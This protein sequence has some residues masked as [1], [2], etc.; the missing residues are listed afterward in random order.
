MQ[1]LT[2]TTWFTRKLGLVPS[3]TIVLCGF[4]ATAQLGLIVNE[5]FDPPTLT[6]GGW[7]GNAASV[8]RQYVSEGVNGSTAV[9]MSAELLNVDGQVAYVG[10][11]LY[12]NGLIMGNDRA[13][14]GNTSLSFDVKVDRPGLLNVVFGLQSF[15]GYFFNY[16][17]PT[18]G[19][20]ASRGIIPLGSYIPGK[21]KTVVVPLDNSLWIQDPYAGPE[22]TAP[23]D[24]TGKTYQMWIQVDS[25]GL[26]TYGSFSITIDNVKIITKNPMVP[27]KSASA[28]QVVPVTTNPSGY[29]V[30]EAGVADNL[31]RFTEIVTPTPAGTGDVEITAANGDKLFG[32]LYFLSDT[33]VLVAL[34]NGTGRFEDAKGSY[35]ATLNWTV[36][37]SSFT[38]TAT[39]SLSTV[40]SNKQ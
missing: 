23:F 27:W 21:F 3:M 16:F 19:A 4:S 22:F 15:E 5:T 12:Q 8:S 7:E 26:P 1:T 38:A 9:Q 24:P 18:L 10:T 37:M 29:I 20:T 6:L 2:R 13:T 32:T 14:L 17:T 30:V 40:G 33:E 31:G 35:I 11:G 36:P 28:G 39:G 34:D 25:G